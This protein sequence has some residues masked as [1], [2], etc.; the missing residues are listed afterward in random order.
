[1]AIGLENG[2]R[3]SAQ[4]HRAL[5]LIAGLVMAIVVISVISSTEDVSSKTSPSDQ[6]RPFK[7]FEDI[8]SGSDESSQGIDTDAPPDEETHSPQVSSSSFDEWFRV[9]SANQ[10][11]G[12]S[13]FTRDKKKPRDKKSFLSKADCAAAADAG[14]THISNDCVYECEAC[15][16]PQYRCGTNPTPC[17][18]TQGP[19]RGARRGQRRA[20]IV[21]VTQLIDPPPP[22]RIPPAPP[23]P[24]AAGAAAAVGAARRQ[25][26][27]LAARGGLLPAV[28]GGAALPR[29]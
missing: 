23:H 27:L 2:R 10:W 19:G 14:L 24:A 17:P 25:V 11:F 16:K 15:E 26:R 5:V 22:S 7:T 12:S 29:G 4:V 28:R 6:D 1:M 18:S 8:L 9:A 21:D 13:T 20:A 3:K